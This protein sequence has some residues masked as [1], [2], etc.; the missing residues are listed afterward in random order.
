MSQVK[1]HERVIARGE[2]AYVWDE[3]GNRVLDLPAGMYYCNVGHGRPEIAS[4]IAAQIETLEAYHTFQS[5]ANR[6]AIELANRLS[7]LGP[8]GQGAKVFF[9][10]N[11]SDAIEIACKLARRYWDA[12]GTPSKRTIVTREHSY[13]G[14]H[15]FGTSIGG[16]E[17][18]RAGYGPL[19]PEVARVDKHSWKALEQHLGQVGADTVAAFVCEP[20]M[21]AGGMIF[22]ER[23]YLNQVERI[24]RE[25]EV[26]FVVDEVIT[27]FGR[28]G[29]L[30]ASDRFGLQPDILVFGKGATSGYIPLSGALIGARVAEPFWEDGGTEIFRHGLTFGGHPAACTAALIN[31]EILER[32]QLIEGVGRLEAALKAAVASLDTSANVVEIRTGVGLLAG[33]RLENPAIAEAVCR[34]CYADGVLTRA[35]GTDSDTIQFSPPLVITTEEIERA[36]EVVAS[37]IDECG[38]GA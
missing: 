10:G 5:Y 6:P 35:G 32:E 29:V 27:G 9:G 33:I 8:V 22:P 11:G 18:F 30:F 4:A 34:Q 3:S 14:M 20:V 31:L 13:H 15:G 2:G 1:G 7:A 37:A 23:N 21:G 19:I 16:Q 38:G 17:L 12:L 36:V 25:N 26:L 24:C 28:L